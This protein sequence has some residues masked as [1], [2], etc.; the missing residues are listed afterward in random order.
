[1]NET[2]DQLLRRL[3][4]V[5]ARAAF[6]AWVAEEEAESINA[7]RVLADDA[8]HNFARQPNDHTNSID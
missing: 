1:V 8:G 5:Y 7:P 4:I 3:A 2:R 6:R